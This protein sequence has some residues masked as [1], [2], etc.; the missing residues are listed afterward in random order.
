VKTWIQRQKNIIDFTLSSLLRRKGKNAGLLLVYTLVVFLLASVIFF[1]HAI[2]REA[3]LVLDGAPDMIV[4][5]MIAGR[6][7]P[8][9]RGYIDKLKVIRGIR[10]IKGRLWGYY[11]DAVIGANYTLM[12]SEE[13]SSAEGTIMVGQ[14]VARTRL[15]DPGDEVEFKTHDGVI[16]NLTVR[17]M[18]P[19]E[20]ELVSSDLI[21]ISEGDFRKLFGLPDSHVT[22]LILQIG[23]PREQITIAEKIA[24]LLPDTRIILKEE[25]LRTYD[26]LFNWRG[27]L[28]LVVLFGTALAFIIFAWD[29]ASGL[30]ME[31]RRETG[32]LKALGWE[33]SDVILLK[34]WEG[35]AISLSA[36][37]IGVIL[38]Y[39][40]VFFVSFALF[41]P[42]L[43]GWAVLYPKF[44]LT[45]FVNPYQIVT[46]FFLT[47]V[48]YTVA[49]I[50]PSWR[51]ATIDPDVVMRE[52]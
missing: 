7:D 35:M 1:T 32:I 48:P 30:S 46:L 52:S 34:F 4:Q 45:P 49:T 50:I 26:T 22:D 14:G 25:L 29:K 16:F 33:T 43:K 51:A 2:K 39:V 28:M 41:E 27:G 10:S 31:E 20:S 37:F 15:L 9:P 23:N 11:Y 12:V 24:T 17:G 5:R 47:V 13:P 36:F 8:I 3:S 21:L 40:H 19:A 42:V 6:Q 38:A 18:F 44:K